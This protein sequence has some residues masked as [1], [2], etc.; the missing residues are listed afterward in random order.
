MQKKSREQALDTLKN[1]KSTSNNEYTK[2]PKNNDISIN[3]RPVS[4]NIKTP[5]VPTN[6]LSFSEL[7]Q[8]PLLFLS[9]KR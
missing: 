1:K 6:R 9:H 8:N 5:E 7:L 2:A 3:S 4:N